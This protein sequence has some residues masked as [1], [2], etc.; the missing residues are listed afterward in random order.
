MYEAI[1]LN[2]DYKKL[3]PYYN[4]NMFYYHY[5]VLYKN[6]INE[7]NSILSKFNQNRLNNDFND[8]QSLEDKLSF[9]AD[10][11]ILHSLFFENLTPIP[12][13]TLLSQELIEHIKKDFISYN[14]FINELKQAALNIQGPGWVVFGYDRYLKKLLIIQVENHMNQI[15]VDF[16]PLLV[17]DVWEHSYYLQYKTNKDNYIKNLFN[18]LNLD[19]VSERY[20]KIGIRNSKIY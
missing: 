12:N 3:E 1:K 13:K 4:Q 15:L 5:Y 17:I 11:Y 10:S 16:I 7:L 8:I 18:I 20:K 2:Y 14:V 6:Y 9:N 19:V